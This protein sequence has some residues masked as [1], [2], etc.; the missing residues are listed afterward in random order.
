MKG[1]SRRGGRRT[2]AAATVAVALVVPVPLALGQPGTAGASATVG[3]LRPVA[4]TQLK[5]DP[6]LEAP[7]YAQQA[8]ASSGSDGWWCELP[9]ATEMPNNFVATQRYVSPLS[10]TVGTYSSYAT[11]YVMRRANG[12]T[13][14]PTTAP[15]IIVSSDVNSTVAPPAH[16]PYHAPVHATGT[17]TVVKGVNG[18]IVAGKHVVSVT[19]R[20]PTSG[21]PKY[22]RGVVSVSVS[23]SGIP[24]STLLAVARQV[25]PD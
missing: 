6:P 18:T 10:G 4:C 3:P 9:H 14:A 1:T 23:G 2:T 17:A 5:S 25:K 21:T 12:S 16:L 20:Y 22:L 13:P 15:T 8:G 11:E 24:E 7:Y 19:W